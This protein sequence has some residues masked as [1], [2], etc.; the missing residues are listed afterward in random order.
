MTHG[1]VVGMDRKDSE[2][3]PLRGTGSV[4]M[5]VWGVTDPASN[6]IL[7]RLRKRWAVGGTLRDRFKVGAGSIAPH[8]TPREGEAPFNHS[9]DS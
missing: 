5:T 8:H 2:L 7:H 3:K 1:E 4:D 9:G 6:G